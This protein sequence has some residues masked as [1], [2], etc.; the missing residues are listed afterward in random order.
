[1]KKLLLLLL[2]LFFILSTQVFGKRVAVLSQLARPRTMAVDEDRLYVADRTTVFV[3]S[4]KDYRL[5][6]QFGR[7]GE[8]PAEFKDKIYLIDIQA[9]HIIVNSVGKLSYL[10]KEGKFIKEMKTP[11]N[12]RRFRVLG[13]KFIGAGIVVDNGI[14]YNTMNIYDATVKKEKEVARWEVEFQPGKGTKAFA[15][16]LSADIC[17]DKL[18][19]AV[20][21]DFV[22][23]VFDENGQKLYAITKEY[24]RIKVTEKDKNRVIHYLKTDPETKQLLEMLKPIKFPDYYPAVRKIAAD[25][26]KVY[27]ITWKKEKENYE[28]LVFHLNGKFLKRVLLPLKNMNAV[29]LYP[30]AVKNGKLYQLIESMDEEEWELHLHNLDD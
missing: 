20:K 2:A 7:E 6:Q 29:D 12:H 10:T 25:G 23:D 22:I 28:I 30:F 9:D 17:G 4:L 15:R 11:A 19:L 21:E 16:T 13:K 14:L 18:L 1:M 24:R 5:L 26:Q 27:A 3:Y 8:G